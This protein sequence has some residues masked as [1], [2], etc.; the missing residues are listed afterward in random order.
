MYD[1]YYTPTF[2]V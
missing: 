2:I 1:H